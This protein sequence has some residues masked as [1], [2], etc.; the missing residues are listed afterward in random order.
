V[1]NGQIFFE[2]VVA[3][4]TAMPRDL[5]FLALKDLA[6]RAYK[7]KTGQDLKYQ[8]R[9]NCDSMSNTSGWRNL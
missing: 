1:A 8:A 3:D 6:A 4:P 2:E 5:G 9:F 7:E